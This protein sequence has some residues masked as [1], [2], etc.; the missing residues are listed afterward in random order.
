M[1]T[2]WLDSVETYD[3][4]QLHAHWILRRTGLVGDACVAFRGPCRVEAAEMADLED[5]LAGSE[6]AGDDMVHLLWESFTCNDLLLAVHRQR[7][8]AAQAG[9]FLQETAHPP[10]LVRRG[11]DLY[12][13]NRKLSISVATCTPVSTL[14]HFAVNVTTA[15]TPVPTVGLEDLGVDPGVFGKALLE[16]AAAEQGSIGEARARARVRGES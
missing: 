1:Q 13:G 4:S 15:G 11:D 6:I 10:T 16:R 14:I 5:L 12:V 9:E 8:L 3:G 7:L 2:R